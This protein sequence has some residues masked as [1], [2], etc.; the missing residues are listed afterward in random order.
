MV[1]VSPATAA[2]LQMRRRWPSSASLAAA[3]DSPRVR[4][5]TS[6]SGVPSGTSTSNSTRNSMKSSYSLT[7]TRC[8]R[9]R[10]RQHRGTASSLRL[11]RLARGGDDPPGSAEVD[12]A[13]AVEVAGL[14]V[15]GEEVERVAT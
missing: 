9:V 11:D 4:C 5:S 15:L 8:R 13:L 12:E 6:L 2:R 1:V 14:L 7:G 10:C 3:A